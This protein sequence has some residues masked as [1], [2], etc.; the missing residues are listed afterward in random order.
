MSSVARLSPSRSSVI[1]LSQRALKLAITGQG[2]L[3]RCS[4]RRCSCPMATQSWSK[5]LAA[6][7]QSRFAT[8]CKQAASPV[9]GCIHLLRAS[10]CLH[11]MLEH[12]RR[13][14]AGA[15]CVSR[16]TGLHGLAM[17]HSA[18]GSPDSMPTAF[19]TA[20][21]EAAHCNATGRV[22]AG[23]AAAAHGAAVHSVA[24]GVAAAHDDAGLR[25][26]RRARAFDRDAAPL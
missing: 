25:G 6:A 18:P 16:V 24:T 19:P 17:R 13:G 11:H 10:L 23:D 12:T 7:L 9:A 26:L 14:A 1:L 4:S 3:C 21:R 15:C 5:L 2:P 8:S 22:C 20:A